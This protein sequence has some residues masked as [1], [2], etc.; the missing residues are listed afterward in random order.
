[1]TLEQELARL[2]HRIRATREA[3]DALY[4]SQEPEEGVEALL[5]RLELLEA[6]EAERR[7]ERKK[8][9]IHVAWECGRIRAARRWERI[10]EKAGPLLAELQRLDEERK[11]SRPAFWRAMVPNR[12]VAFAGAQAIGANGRPGYRRKVGRR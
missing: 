3:I 11:R 6:L 8:W 10:L 12:Y 7:H 2:D 4:A 5:D 1:M 9:A